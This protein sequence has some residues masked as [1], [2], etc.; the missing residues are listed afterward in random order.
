[1]PA[2]YPMGR[3]V[4]AGTIS[5]AASSASG[6]Q[7]ISVGFTPSIIFFLF[8]DD[9]DESVTSNGWDNGTGMM[10]CSA[11]KS[12]NFLT[13]LLGAIGLASLTSGKSQFSIWVQGAT[14]NGHKGYVSSLDANGFTIDWTRIGSG[15][16][17]NGRYVAM[18]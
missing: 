7:S 10:A 9:A 17:V 16:N 18:Q 8:A 12:S 3:Q 11:S 1:M 5:R 2:I 14:G 6:Q 13:S 15:S 4:A